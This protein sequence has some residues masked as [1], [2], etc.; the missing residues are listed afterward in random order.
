MQPEDSDKRRFGVWSK[1]KKKW[2]HGFIKPRRTERKKVSPKHRETHEEALPDRQGCRACEN[3]F[4]RDF[5]VTVRE[6]LRVCEGDRGV[7]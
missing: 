4:R 5:R 2:S 7:G 1:T 6:G 3:G